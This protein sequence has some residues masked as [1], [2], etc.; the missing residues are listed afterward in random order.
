VSLSLLFQRGDIPL[1]DEVISEAIPSFEERVRLVGQQFRRYAHAE[2]PAPALRALA[3]A[4][5]DDPVTA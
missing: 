3:A 2:P 5:A 1:D 4:M